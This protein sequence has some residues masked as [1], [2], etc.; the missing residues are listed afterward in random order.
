MTEPNQ[1]VISRL[2]ADFNSLSSQFAKVSSE[3][4]ELGTVLA[5]QHRALAKLRRILDPEGTE[6]SDVEE[7]AIEGPEGR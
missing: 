4:L 3:L 1:A 5:R 7:E 2:S 6:E